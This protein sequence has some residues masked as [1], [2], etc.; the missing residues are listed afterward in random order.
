M[1]TIKI[2]IESNAEQVGKTFEELAKNFKN[3]TGDAEDLRKQIK[4]LKGE[5]FKLTPGT[6][7]YGKVLEQLGSKMNQLGD[8]TQELRVATGGLDTV[9][10]T[11]T[12]ATA[13]MAAGFTAASGVIAL[14]GGDTENLQKTFVKL[15]AVMAITTGLKGFAAFEK[16]TKRASI[17]LKAY[18]AQS[19][20]ARTA[21]MQQTTSTVGL[22]AAEGAAATAATGLGTAIKGVTA[23]IA[24]NPIG[25]VLVA[26]TAAIAAIT[27]FV[28]A[29]KEAKQQAEEY[30]KVLEKSRGIALSFTEQLEREDSQF[31]LHVA[32]LKTLGVTQAE[33]N[34]LMKKHLE[35]E[36]SSLR[37]RKATLESLIDYNKEN[38]K[39]KD[40]LEEW[41]KE[42]DEVNSK[43]QD[44]QSTLDEMA[45]NT[46]PKFAQEADAGFTALERSLNLQV[47]SGDLSENGS[48][49]Q[50]I[51][52]WQQRIEDTQK[53]LDKANKKR[54]LPMNSESVNAELDKSIEDY[55]RS[56]NLWSKRIVELEE[57]QQENTA[58]AVKS[59]RDAAK[60][61]AQEHSK[62]YK[63]LT[64]DFDKDYKEMFKNVSDFDNKIQ[65]L[66]ESFGLSDLASEGRMRASL[67]LILKDIDDFYTKSKKI[68]TELVSE[69]KISYDDYNT[70]ITNLELKVQE[71]R[72]LASHY[73]QDI[74]LTD[75]STVLNNNLLK[76]VKDLTSGLALI[77]QLYKDGL[78][79]TEEYNKAYLDKL[80][81]FKQSMAEDG[82]DIEQLYKNLLNPEYLDEI[83]N[84][85]EDG[86]EQTLREFLDEQKM[87]ANEYVEFLKNL[88]AQSGLILP[89]ELAK[90][91]TDETVKIIN[92]QFAVI[93]KNY[94]E[95]MDM[96]GRYWQEKMRSWLEGGTDTSYWGDSASTTYKKMQQQADDLYKLLHSEYEQEIQLLQDKMSLLDENS[97]AYADYYAK[98]Q[99]LRQADADAQA[100]QQTASLANIRQYSQDIMETAGKFGDAISGLAGA[101]GS[102]YAEQAE[103][104]KEMYGENSEEYKKYLK[105]EGNMKIAQVWTDAATGIMSAW[106][107]SESLGPIAG[108]ILAAIQTA[109]LLA[110]ATASTMQIKRQTQATA[111]GDAN[112]TANVGQLTDRVIY[113]DAQNADQTAKLNADYNQGKGVKVF[114]TQGDIEKANNEHKVAVTQN[115]F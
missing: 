15:Q 8:T 32:R 83:V 20:L 94:S 6:E 13:T 89:P 42:L 36:A 67:Q 53:L 62:N 90:S 9:F 2:V 22:A 76:N 49:E 80:E 75:Y 21:T 12:Q 1:D 59:S 19:K 30:N 85:L 56:I 52:Y 104:A 65:Q 41:S 25:A 11:T 107:T 40:K 23:A 17:S 81:A 47:L 44:T 5:L 84:T 64:E 102:Y 28:S 95:R 70:Y 7:E 66:F 92:S 91:I 103:Q 18:I 29:S 35:T 31:N 111:S 63:K 87:T 82:E 33:I 43:L 115:Q 24:A 109:A 86:S 105:K 50:K 10:Q 106:A 108:P 37:Q 34:S 57:K 77:N 74:G 98:L 16:M 101:M 14:F 48:I 97:Q 88:F 55:T 26:I 73:S 4:D 38:T 96:F 58:K 3:T 99:E 112:T 113:G 51:S 114:V 93:E 39:V 54:A 60:K 45:A 69:N 110:T 68:A 27:H 46:L 72:D 78:I 100:A 61:L 71:M 79:K